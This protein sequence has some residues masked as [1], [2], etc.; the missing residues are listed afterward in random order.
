LQKNEKATQYVENAIESNSC[1]N[2]L[3]DAIEAIEATAN[4][5]E[6]N[7]PEILDLVKTVESLENEKDITQLV[8]SSANV[9]RKL[10]NL[11]PNLSEQPYK[12][13]DASS[14]D[15]IKSFNDLAKQLEVVSYNAEIQMSSGVR[16]SLK[17]SSK[18]ISEISSFLGNLNKSLADFT[19]LCVKDND[20]NTALLNTI[21]DIMEDMAALFNSLGGEEKSKGI[22]KNRTFVKQIVNTFKDLDLQFQLD[23]GSISALAQ[24]MDELAQVIESVGV[25]KLSKELGVELNFINNF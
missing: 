10:S 12:V 2:N 24:T 14:E 15:T 9:L 7:G 6:N 8:R 11:V 4:L 5:V 1:L 17:S 20:Y 13:C 3:D 16:V 22:K 18:M 23:C 19:G 21:G 25:E